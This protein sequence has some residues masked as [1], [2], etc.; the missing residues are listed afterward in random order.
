MAKITYITHDGEEH[1]VDADAGAR[2]R[3]AKD[4]VLVSDSRAAALSDASHAIVATPSIR[5][6]DDLAACARLP[7][8]GIVLPKAETGGDCETRNR[9]RGTR[10]RSSEASWP[11]IQRASSSGAQ[12]EPTSWSWPARTIH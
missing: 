12:R 2:A 10:G 5:H 3:A 7:L 11:Y 6:A 9:A 4:G 8:A 1:K